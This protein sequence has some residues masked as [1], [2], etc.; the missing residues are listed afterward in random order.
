[1]QLRFEPE[2]LIL[3]FA[4]QIYL[5]VTSSCLRSVLCSVLLLARLHSI[6]LFSVVGRR[7]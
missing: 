5:L 6:V 4:L 3:Y 1:M 2:H 7:L